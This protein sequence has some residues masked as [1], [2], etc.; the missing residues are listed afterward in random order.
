MIV[1]KFDWP[2]H[3][4]T[5]YLTWM[6]M[7]QIGLHGAR[8]SYP[9]FRPILEAGNLDKLGADVAYDDPWCATARPATEQLIALATALGGNDAGPLFN[10]P[11]APHPTTVMRVVPDV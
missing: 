1:D 7:M 5:R 9:E 8:G 3:Q 2:R 4:L 11:E 6:Q 10:V